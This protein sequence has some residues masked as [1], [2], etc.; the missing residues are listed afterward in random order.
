MAGM[1]ASST[2]SPARQLP[3]RPLRYGAYLEA[4]A[5]E[6]RKSRS[7][8]K[9]RLRL[10]AAGARLLERSGYRDLNVEE[11]SA[12]TEMAKGTFYI[13]FKS[14]DAYL[15]ELASGYVD[16]ELATF[17]AIGAADPFRYMLDQSRWYLGVWNANAGMLRCLVQ[18]S[19]L[20]VEARALWHRRNAAIVDRIMAE[21]FP[22]SP[23]DGADA[24]LGRLALRS[25]GAMIDRWMFDRHRLAVGPG[26]EAEP[27]DEF[28]LELLALLSFRALY[29]ANPPVADL[30]R[31]RALLAWPTVRPLD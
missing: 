20:Q 29:A 18:M 25:L 17:P 6:I 8:E 15:I 26:I 5:S 13:Y 27:D 10:L 7:G 30:D 11:V 28:M 12:E 3:A 1:A 4:L 16:F 9:T 23:G 19:E 14:K 2:S 22:A 31:T 24:G 21:L